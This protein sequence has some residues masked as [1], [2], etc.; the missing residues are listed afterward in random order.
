VNNKQ[1]KF[2]KHDK[3]VNVWIILQ[4]IMPKSSQDDS[5]VSIETISKNYESLKDTFP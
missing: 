5:K 4:N 1:D 2:I 3:L